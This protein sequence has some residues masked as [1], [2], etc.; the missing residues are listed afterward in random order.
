MSDREFEIIRELAEKAQE[1]CEAR[2]KDCYK[3][4]MVI[5]GVPFCCVVS[6]K[7]EYRMESARRRD[8]KIEKLIEQEKEEKDRKQFNRFW[9]MK[10]P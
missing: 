8:E 2:N 3:C 1:F 4:S 9:L 5:E 7:E 6:I 10:G